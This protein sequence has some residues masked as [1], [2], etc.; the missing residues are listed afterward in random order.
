M[1]APDGAASPLGRTSRMMAAPTSLM[2][3]RSSTVSSLAREAASFCRS[4]SAARCAARAFSSSW[5]R[6]RATS[7][8]PC[9]AECSDA[10]MNQFLRQLALGIAGA[11]GQM[12]ALGRTILLA[13]LRIFERGIIDIHLDHEGSQLAEIRHPAAGAR[14]RALPPL[15]PRG[16]FR[17]RVFPATWRVCSPSPR[18]RGARRRGHRPSCA[19]GARV[20]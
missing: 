6:L 15:P 3:C 7:S 12:I 16:A 1:A 19:H 14:P 18:V 5:Q 4:G 10:Q 13:P 20:A 8:A 17:L 2:A 11:L 9:V